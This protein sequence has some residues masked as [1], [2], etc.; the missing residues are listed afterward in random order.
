MMNAFAMEDT[1]GMRE[2]MLYKDSLVSTH[3]GEEQNAKALEI[4]ADH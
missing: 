3:I 4:F 2:M 1:T